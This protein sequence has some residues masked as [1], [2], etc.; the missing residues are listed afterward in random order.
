MDATLVARGHRQPI[1]KFAV[2][3]KKNPVKQ[4]SFRGAVKRAG[5]LKPIPP[6]FLA[7]FRGDVR[8]FINDGG[9]W[10]M[11]M[12]PSVPQM[13]KNKETVAEAE[14]SSRE[15]FVRRLEHELKRVGALP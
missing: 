15:V 2:S 12:S 11:L 13:M 1:T 10:R 4:G 9:R 7:P 6:A 5:G 14:K 3:P 8:A